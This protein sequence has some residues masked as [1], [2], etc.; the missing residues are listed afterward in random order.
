VIGAE[1]CRIGMGVGAVQSQQ[2][3]S[4]SGGK[5]IPVVGCEAE[6]A[7][8]SR[9][10]RRSIGDGQQLE[11]IVPEHRQAVAGSKR[12]HA[13]RCQAEAERL[14]VQRSLRQIADTDDE[15]IQSAGHGVLRI[16]GGP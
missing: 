9:R 16:A 12:M 8:C 10:H 2:R 6:A 1:A 4:F 7:R 3:H 11:K 5:K 13:G 15:V 14:P